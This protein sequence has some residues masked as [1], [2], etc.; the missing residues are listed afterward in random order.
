MVKLSISQL[1][2]GPT[3]PIDNVQMIYKQ[4]NGKAKNS[5]GEKRFIDVKGPWISESYSKILVDRLANG[6]YIKRDSQVIMMMK[7]I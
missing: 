6:N 7:T 1:P 5:K 4:W 2:Y 3:Q